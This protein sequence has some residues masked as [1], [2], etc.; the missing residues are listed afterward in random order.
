MWVCVCVCPSHFYIK[1]IPATCVCVNIKWKRHL[2]VFFWIWNTL[3][4]LT[5]C[6]ARTPSWNWKHSL[7]LLSRIT[8]NVCA[9]YLNIKN[10]WR[11]P[12]CILC[13]CPPSPALCKL[14]IEAQD[15]I[16]FRY[17]CEWLIK[18]S[19][20]WILQSKHVAFAGFRYWDPSNMLK[21]TR[22]WEAI[23]KAFTCLVDQK[24]THTLKKLKRTRIII[25]SVCVCVC[26]C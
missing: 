7:S 3:N 1:V 17:L 2:C 8:K 24:K 16:Y 9:F 25:L 15:D 5:M 14:L 20:L 11:N 22:I 12:Y 6:G 10:D 18:F 19:Y 21:F 23:P 26:M 13:T 4:T